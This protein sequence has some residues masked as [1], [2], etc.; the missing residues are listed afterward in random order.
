MPQAVSRPS[1]E[2]EDPDSQ[3]GHLAHR[4][5]GTI[6]TRP[7]QAGNWFVSPHAIASAGAVLQRNSAWSLHMRCRMTASLRATA[8]RALAMPRRC[9]TRMPH[10]FS[11]DH[12]TAR[13]QR[14]RRLIERGAGELV[15]ASADASLDIG[16]ARLVA[17]RR[18][19]EVGR[20]VA[21][22]SE[23]LGLIDRRPEGERGK[24]SHAWHRH[25]PPAY[26]LDPD[27]I[28][29]ALRQLLDLARHRIKHRKQRLDDVG[30]GSID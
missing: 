20:D 19:T 17:S 10:A 24:R 25:Q 8:T 28:Q 6:A 30:D 23:A 18:E 4:P 2:P 27:R 16:L 1:G 29:H 26:R 22:S 3:R 15:A 7:F 5:M 11:V 13:Q 12:L 21:G 9:A 14:V